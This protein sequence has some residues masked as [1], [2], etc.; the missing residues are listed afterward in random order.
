MDFTAFTYNYFAHLYLCPSF[1]AHYRAL[2]LD[3]ASRVGTDLRVYDH[4]ALANATMRCCSAR[5]SQRDVMVSLSV[6]CRGSVE[7]YIPIFP[8]HYL[9]R[10]HISKSNF[11]TKSF[12]RLTYRDGRRSAS[13]V[14][15]VALTRSMVTIPQLIF[16][17]PRRQYL[18]RYSPSEAAQVIFSRDLC[19]RPGDGS[20]SC[21]FPNK[22]RAS[23]PTRMTGRSPSGLEYNLG[24]I[25]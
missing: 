2:I 8:I 14:Y 5:I 16:L 1:S 22:H 20:S 15:N 21:K 3:V 23:D 17:I 18:R 19:T 25:L 24:V 4:E 6:A 9:V 10:M 11:G 13:C 7:W 12:H